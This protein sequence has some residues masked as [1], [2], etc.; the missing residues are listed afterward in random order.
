MTSSGQAVVLKEKVTFSDMVSQPILSFGRLMRS[1]WS[2]DGQKSC[3]KNGGLEVPLAFQNQS[4]VVDASIRVITEPMVIRTLGVKLGGELESM[5]NSGYG[6]KKKD[7][8]W[9]GL[10]LS[11]KFQSPQF[12]PGFRDQGE[13]VCR[14]TLVE[15]DGGWELVEMA[16]PLDGLEEQ[17][18]EIEELREVGL[19]K[20]MTFVAPEVQFSWVP[21]Q[22][23]KSWQSLRL[24]MMSLRNLE[25]LRFLE[26]KTRS[27]A[28][29]SMIKWSSMKLEWLSR[30]RS[31]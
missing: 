28:E 24:E 25:E 11:T 18:G 9:V 14:S 4:L 31:G 20:V 6:W 23:W 17:E 5:A 2:I 16:E 19:S 29:T 7:D 30:K 8:F 3:L 22:T 15:R 1:G 13:G 21:N 27:R 26:E 10:H 12:I